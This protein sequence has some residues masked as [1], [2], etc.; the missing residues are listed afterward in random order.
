MIL[1]D[2][3]ALVALVNREDRRHRR[4]RSALE[5]IR[6]PLWTVWPAL[7][8]AMLL[9]ETIPRG[10]DAV[11][12]MIERGA[13]RIAAL[14][15]TDVPRIRDLMMR[16]RDRRMGLAG[17]SLARV[18]ERE[19]AQRIFTVKRGVFEACRTR[20]RLRFTILP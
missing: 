3:G 7:A 16:Y 18:A 14:A 10:Q 2:G 9:L 19:G 20:G 8:Q 11:W 17:A 1:V 13:L 5:G 4:C 15:E 12:E 6:E